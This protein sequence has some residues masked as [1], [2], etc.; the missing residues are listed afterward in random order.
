MKHEKKSTKDDDLKK[1]RELITQAYGLM[2]SDPQK[3]IQVS[4]EALKLSEKHRFG[5][6]SGYGIHAYRSGLFPSE[7]LL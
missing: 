7:S 3:C 2:N 5:V 4:K 6:G 1:V